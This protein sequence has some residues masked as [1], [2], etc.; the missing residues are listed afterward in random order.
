[1]AGASEALPPM[2][3]RL[4]LQLAR[5]FRPA[6]LWLALLTSAE[7]VVTLTLP[8]LAG[9]LLGSAAAGV[10]PAD[11]RIVALLVGALTATAVLTASVAYQSAKTSA[12][13]LAA[14]RQRVFEHVQRLPIGFHESRGKGDTLALLTYEIARLS[15]FLT[16]TLMTLPAKL[17]SVAGATILMFRIDAR[18]AL[19]VPVLIPAFYLILKIAGR[20]L[21]SLAVSV[22][23]AEA[24]VVATAEEMLEML[25]ATK[26]FTREEGE[27]LRYR[28]AVSGVAA[29]Q[30]REGRILAIL[31]P[32]V[33]LVAALAAV[34]V[35]VVAGE[36]VRGG[37]LNQA[38]LFSFIFYAALLTRPIS[39]LAQVYGQ[40]NMARGTLARMQSVLDQPTELL[41]SGAGVS[42][43]SGLIR[44]DRVDFAYPGRS[45]LLREVSFEIRPGEVVAL[46]GANGSGK[47]AIINLLL[48]Y[49]ERQGGL[50]ALDGSDVSAMNVGD[51][52]RQIGLVPQTPM[53]FNASIA[54]NIAFGAPGASQAQIDEAARLA[55]AA[56]F[57][58]SLPSGMDTVIGDRGVRLSGGQRQRIALARA[59]I[60]DPPILIFDEA[61][62]MFDEEGEERFIRESAAALKGRTVI[63]VT[64]RPA[65]LALAG[66]ALRLRDGA[67]VD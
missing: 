58:G 15:D 29:L 52:R 38:Q 3:F 44:F 16:G 64:H 1:M 48:R 4:L 22:Q 17:L 41:G 62:S 59:L 53:L 25:P 32:A 7:A 42:R 19:I 34:F 56:E 63:I 47:T 36:T 54:Q 6:L 51:L 30:T 26:A 24:Q 28:D 46:L 67:I 31:G 12:D 45:Q 2:T 23:R 65:T 8:W 5:P 10:G 21:R 33:A 50:I 57:I 55:Q 27:A 13:L 37:G 18:L 49:Y 60:K 9:H 61:T 20:R 35:L 66:R 39:S 40:T 11:S 43:A 14:L